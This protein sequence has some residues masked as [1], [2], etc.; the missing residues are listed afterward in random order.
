MVFCSVAMGCIWRMPRVCCSDGV[1]PQFHPPADQNEG[2]GGRF[3]GGFEISVFGLVH[4]TGD[5]SKLPDVSVEL[6]CNT[7]ED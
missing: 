3:S 7:I 4:E 6:V 1:L 2:E 5:L